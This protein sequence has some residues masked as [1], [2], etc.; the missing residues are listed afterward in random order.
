MH[1]A[2]TLELHD[3]ALEDLDGEAIQLECAGAR[4]AE[5]LDAAAPLEEAPEGS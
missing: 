2:V 5:R 4:V 1:R 3:L